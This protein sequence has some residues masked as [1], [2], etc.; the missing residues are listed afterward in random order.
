MKRHHKGTDLYRHQLWLR[1]ASDRWNTE[2]HDEKYPLVIVGI[3]PQDKW[4]HHTWETANSKSTKRWLSNFIEKSTCIVHVT[5]CKTPCVCVCVCVCVCGCACKFM[6]ACLCLHKCVCVLACM[7]AWICVCIF[8]CMHL[9][10]HV[11]TRPYACV[12][13]CLC[14]CPCM[15]GKAGEEGKKERERERESGGWRIRTKRKRVSSLTV[16]MSWHL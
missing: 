13:V 1:C 4:V 8:V 16:A 6:H 3:W 10:A 11:H 12:W 15:R 7:N 5:M 9:C 2:T 14:I